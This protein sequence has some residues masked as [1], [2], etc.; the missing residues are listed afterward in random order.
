MTF[1]DIEQEEWLELFGSVGICQ[2]IF[3]ALCI[4]FYEEAVICGTCLI[5][6]YFLIR[7][8][9]KMLGNFPNEFLI[10]TSIKNQRLGQNDRW[11]WVYLLLM[12]VL[13]V[14]SIKRQWGNRKKILSSSDYKKYDFRFRAP[15][16]NPGT[17]AAGRGAIS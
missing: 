11:L 12:V 5:G 16:A 15:S 8:L 6:S 10:Y 3:S 4:I 2:L 14:V 17:G 13:C 1:A 9:A 7:G